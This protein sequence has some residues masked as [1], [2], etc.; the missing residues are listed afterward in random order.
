MEKL[1]LIAIIDGVVVSVG[2]SRSASIIVLPWHYVLIVG[3]GWPLSILVFVSSW[4]SPLSGL[5]QGSPLSLNLSLGSVVSWPLVVGLISHIGP[6]ISRIVLNSRGSS[7]IRSFH[8][9]RLSSHSWR[10]LSI[11]WS[12]SAFLLWSVLLISVS[13]GSAIR[14]G[15]PPKS[16]LASV[17]VVAAIK[18]L[19]LPKWSSTKF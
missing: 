11:V 16:L 2:A 13:Q 17:V 5:L 14:W 3:L 19:S 7:L 8:S 4:W 6:R 18:S 12:T 1:L 15:S 9:L 10:I